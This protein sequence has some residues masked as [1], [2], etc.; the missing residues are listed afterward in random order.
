[1]NTRIT[2]MISIFALAISTQAQPI[3]SPTAIP[4]D[5]VPIASEY[6]DTT[7]VTP[8]VNI[9]RF[10]RKEDEEEYYHDISRVRVVLPYVRM[11]KK[12]YADLE[13]KKDGQSRREFRHYRKDMEKEMREK[14]EKELRNLSVNQGKVLVK[15]INRETGNNCYQ[16]I[17]EV[18]GGIFAWAWQI[19]ARRWDYDLKEKY[20]TKKDWILELAIKSIGPDYNP[21]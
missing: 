13:L 2:L 19:V 15:L 17:K 21:N 20:D 11:A 6:M 9:V 14:F 4:T 5:S 10:K 3:S 1:M 7:I 12:M 18:K 8:D 16:I